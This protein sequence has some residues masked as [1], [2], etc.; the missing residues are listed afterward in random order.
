VTRRTTRT[1]KDSKEISR[2]MSLNKGAD[3]RVVFIGEKEK[4]ERKK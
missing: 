4:K 3:F 1:S 2:K